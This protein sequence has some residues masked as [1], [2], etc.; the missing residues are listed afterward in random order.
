MDVIAG[1]GMRFQV[2]LSAC[3][4]LD[5]ALTGMMFPEGLYQALLQHMDG[6]KQGLHA[7]TLERDRPSL[8]IG[9][10]ISCHLLKSAQAL[11]RQVLQ[12][13][14]RVLV[15]ALFTDKLANAPGGQAHT[16]NGLSEFI[17]H[18]GV[19]TGSNRSRRSIRFNSEDNCLI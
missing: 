4:I 17:Q 11:S 19:W 2:K 13:S 8:Q 12:S 15:G 6:I 18:H 14:I 10:Q 3:G 7:V 16:V 1:H 9:A 5:L